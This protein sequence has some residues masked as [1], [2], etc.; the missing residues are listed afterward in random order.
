MSFT[1]FSSKTTVEPK[2][3]LTSKIRNFG[4]AIIA[5]FVWVVTAPVRFFQYIRG[6]RELAQVMSGPV[7]VPATS[8]N[9]P[10]VI[11]VE[12]DDELVTV[13]KPLPS[14]HNLL[15]L[16]RELT[17]T[18]R[19]HSRET[20]SASTSSNEPSPAATPTVDMSKYFSSSLEQSL[21]QYVAEQKRQAE[22][23]PT[24]TN[25]QKRMNMLFRFGSGVAVGAAIVAAVFGR[26]RP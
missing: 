13:N 9:P 14:R 15:G 17:P 5:S 8:L 6:V 18:L 2:P 4:A 26:P 20:S 11:E 23:I 21:S 12:E 1:P 25:G 19:N 7:L 24:I 22:A 3:S 10:T 16:K